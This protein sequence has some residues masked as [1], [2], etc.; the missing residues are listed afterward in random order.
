MDEPEV[1]EAPEHLSEAELEEELGVTPLSE[2]AGEGPAGLVEGAAAR[3]VVPKKGK[4]FDEDGVCEVV[5]IRPC[6]S[7]GKR[8][9]GLPPIYTP[10][11]LA[12]NAPV[13][14]GWLMYMNHLTSKIVEALAE[15]RAAGNMEEG[16]RLIQE[17]G[18]RLLKSWW[19][20]TIRFKD[21]AK[22]GFQP[23]GVVGKALPQPPVRRMLEADPEILNVSHNAWPK[24]AT[25]GKAPWSNQTGYLIEGIR[26]SPEGSVDW[27][28]RG[29]AGGRLNLQEW[30]AFAVSVLGTTYGSPSR[31]SAETEQDDMD[32]KNTTESQLREKL[33]E[34]NPRLAEALGIERSTPPAAS[35]A[36]AGLSRKDLE[37]ALADQAQT[38]TTRLEETRTTVAEEA[39]TLADSMLEER[40][41]QREVAK[42]AAKLIKSAGLTERWTED[43]TRRYSV[44]PSGP[45]AVLSAVMEAEDPDAALTEQI[46]ADVEHARELIEEVGGVPS[47]KGLGGAE[48]LREDRETR[49][50]KR[51]RGAFREFLAESEADPEKRKKILDGEAVKEMVTEGIAD[52][53]LPSVED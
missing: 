6:V 31:E 44:L 39:R 21:D 46:N 11:M 40:D 33:L 52:V 17:L 14:S 27:V 29:G 1:T 36:P 32:L 23:G 7:R 47:V 51:T 50:K 30:E 18:G 48:K 28:P 41:R 49:D 9:H 26:P 37:E 42:R 25:K 2:H 38:F 10:K 8:I 19:N 43:L 13:Y 45:S 15:A 4:I 20:P 16:S 53:N 5:V 22:Y 24:G 12:E 34:E 35:E 3:L